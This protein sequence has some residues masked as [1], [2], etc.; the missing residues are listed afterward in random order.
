MKCRLED[1]EALLL[2]YS[3]GELESA[4][5]ARVALHV[6]EC[7]ECREFVAGQK[8]VW[9]ALDSWEAPPVSVDFDRRLY[10]AIEEQGSWWDTLARGWRVA[11]LRPMLPLAAAAALVISA[12][13]L[14][15]RPSHPPARN[16]TVTAHVELQPEQVQ[17]AI[18]EMEALRQFTHELRTESG[19]SQM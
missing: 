16:R 11:L 13:V 3:S 2:A 6:E 18:D 15:E 9:Q 7:A 1:R 12:G 8:A 4:E 19:D 5:S 14:L 17:S 10:R